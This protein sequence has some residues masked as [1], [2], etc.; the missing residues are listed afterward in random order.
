MDRPK[1]STDLRQFIGMVN[2][3]RDMWP[4]RAHILRPLTDLSGLKKRA[5]LKWTDEMEE[6]FVKMRLLLAAD[7]LQAY[8]DHNKRFD[9]YTDSSD[10]QLGSCIMQDGRPVAYFSRKLNK[11]QR[12]YITMEKEMLSI[13]A[14]LEEFRSMLLGA[15]IHVFTD[16]KNLTFNNTIKTQRVLRWR[17]KIEEFSP[18]L[19]YIKGKKNILAD[20]LSRLHRMPTPDQLAEGKKM[21]EPVEVT[22]DEDEAEDAFFTDANFLG[23]YDDD[24]RECIEFEC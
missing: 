21:V 11:A 19:H 24:I 7:A 14:T 17:L 20:Q 1:T 16:H 23:Y 4:S 18:T 12:N 6:A 3:Y 10:Y 9:I 22:D 8:P 5:P 13:V 15:D 2:Y